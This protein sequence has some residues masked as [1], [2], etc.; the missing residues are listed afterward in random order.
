M[1]LRRR[2]LIRRDALRRS[3]RMDLQYGKRDAFAS[4]EERRD[5]WDA[6]RDALLARARQGFGAGP[7]A[8]W[9]YEGPPE[10]RAARDW[11]TVTP[12][13][14]IVGICGWQRAAEL[15]ADTELRDRRRAWLKA[16]H[17]WTA[18]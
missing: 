4:D 3:E 13:P 9:D 12:E 10:L 14:A 1:P 7:Q 6:H 15:T 16:H 17:P 5:A 18:A 8:Y 11:R 2:F